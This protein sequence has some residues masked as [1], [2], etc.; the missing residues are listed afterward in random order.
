MSASPVASALR[1]RREPV[2]IAGMGERSI[3][4]AQLVALC[5]QLSPFAE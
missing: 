4:C 1:A 2:A 5:E 3:G